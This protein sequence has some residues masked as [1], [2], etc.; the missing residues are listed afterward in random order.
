MGE[1][2]PQELKLRLE[3]GDRL[4]LLDV[5]QKW[6]TDI[7]RLAGAAHIPAGEID[8]RA[9]ELS[10][11]SEIVVYCHHGVRSAAAAH[12]LRRRG[13]GRVWNL[14]GGIDSWARAIDPE[15]PRY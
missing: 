9:D 11:E 13:F 8:R 4:V 12:H 14:A 5:R 2:T 7:C 10:P 15:M 1:I 3:R 6:E